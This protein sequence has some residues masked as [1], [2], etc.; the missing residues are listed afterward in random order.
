MDQQTDINDQNS[1][2]NPIR[3]KSEQ[4][5]RRDVTDDIGHEQL[6]AGVTYSL[7]NEKEKYAYYVATFRQ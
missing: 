5:T 1:S 2:E 7:E 3:L 6:G 4:K